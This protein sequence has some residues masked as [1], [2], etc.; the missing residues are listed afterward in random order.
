M[1]TTRK[2]ARRTNRARTAD[3]IRYTP[4]DAELIARLG[5]DRA[6]AS[7]YVCDAMRKLHEPDG[8]TAALTALRDVVN[9]AGG[10]G[11]ISRAG[12]GSRPSIYRALSPGGN[13]TLKTLISL[14]DTIGL[15]LAIEMNEGP[16]PSVPR[17]SR[18]RYKGSR[19]GV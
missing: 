18:G 10:V 8:F 2:A 4:P 12:G 19:A 3:S 1:R 13:P 14:L 6:F 17:L 5:T 7:E 11:A 9:A 15:R 16:V